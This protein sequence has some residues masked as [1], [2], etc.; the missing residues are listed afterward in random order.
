MILIVKTSLGRTFEVNSN[1]IKLMSRASKGVNLKNLGLKLK[2]G[3]YIK[4]VCCKG[5]TTIGSREYPSYTALKDNALKIKN[6]SEAQII[7]N[8]INGEVINLK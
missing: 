2:N 7:A 4:D 3:E 1:D 8:N 5:Y 6:E